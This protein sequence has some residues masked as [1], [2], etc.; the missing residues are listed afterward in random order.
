MQTKNQIAP[1]LLLTQRAMATGAFPGPDQQA[2]PSWGETLWRN[3]TPTPDDTHLPEFHG[4]RDR[5]RDTVSPECVLG[6]PSR[7]QGPDRKARR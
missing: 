4:W 2:L 7:E 5:G 3:E 6:W 1:S